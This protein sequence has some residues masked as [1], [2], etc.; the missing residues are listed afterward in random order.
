MKILMT[1]LGF[2]SAALIMAQIVMGLMLRNGQ[3]EPWL[4][5]AHFHSG[6]L[7][8][9]L[10]LTYIAISLWWIASRTNRTTY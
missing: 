4:R 9:L 6:S 3:A 8:G 1:V 7:M 10:S 5:T 2:L